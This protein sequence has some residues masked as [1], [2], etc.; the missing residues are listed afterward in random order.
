MYLKK[1]LN[2]D[3]QSNGGR[4]TPKLR[5]TFGEA[6]NQM[7]LGK[8]VARK[9][10][11]VDGKTPVLSIQKGIYDSTVVITPVPVEIDGIPIALFE[12]GEAGTEKKLPAILHTDGETSGG[13]PP[14]HA[15]MLSH[16]WYV[17]AEIIEPIEE[18]KEEVNKL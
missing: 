15:D 18:T 11:L 8:Q 3:A 7:K 16:D 17:V 10:W 13:W 6:L 5:L 14:V 12:R 2:S 1:I 4:T 9:S